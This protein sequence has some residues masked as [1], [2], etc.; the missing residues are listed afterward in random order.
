MSYIVAIAT[1]TLGGRSAR[2][3]EVMPEEIELVDA[4]RSPL[5]LE[6]LGPHQD[7]GEVFF[8]MVGDSATSDDLVT[9]EKPRNRTL[10]ARFTAAVS[11]LVL[12]GAGVRIA[13]HRAGGDFWHEPVDLIGEVAWSL[14]EFIEDFPDVGMERCISVDN[15][16]RGTLRG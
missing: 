1:Y 12:R 3:Q 10:Q 5:G 6:L 2:A 7:T 4:S 14:D 8:A 11:R 16:S 9:A 13:I 15:V